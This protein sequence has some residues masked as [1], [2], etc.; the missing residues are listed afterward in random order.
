MPRQCVNVH[1]PAKRLDGKQVPQIMEAKAPEVRRFSLDDA[2]ETAEIR[3][4]L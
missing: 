2:P 4:R 1:I 3:S